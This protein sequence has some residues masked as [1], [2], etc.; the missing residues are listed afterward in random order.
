MVQFHPDVA[1]ELIES[2]RFYEQQA[3]GLGER[4][5]KAVETAVG[6]ASAHPEPYPVI[7]AD[8]VRRCLV[9]IFPYAIV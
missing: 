5:L 9:S 8:A 7:H 4:F 6:Q 3:S 2:S 1:D